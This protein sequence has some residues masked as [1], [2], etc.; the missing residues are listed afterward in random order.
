[1]KLDAELTGMVFLHLAKQQMLLFRPDFFLLL[2]C[3]YADPYSKK[4]K[5]PSFTSENRCTS[6]S[7]WRGGRLVTCN[8]DSFSSVHCLTFTSQASAGELRGQGPGA[9]A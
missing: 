3:K 9:M 6:P 2:A 7:I 8:P 4:G 1:M 5:L